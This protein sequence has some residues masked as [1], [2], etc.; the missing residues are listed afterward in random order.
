MTS[1]IRDAVTFSS[2]IFYNLQDILNEHSKEF[3]YWTTM[4]KIMDAHTKHKDNEL[5]NCTLE[6][7]VGLYVLS[8]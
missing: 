4:S 8:L 1:G 6:A 7:L 3:D 5:V 2:D